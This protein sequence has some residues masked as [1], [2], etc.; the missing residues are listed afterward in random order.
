[1]LDLAMQRFFGMCIC[2]K[3]HAL[4]Q[5]FLLTP[6]KSLIFLPLDS[7][8]LLECLKFIIAPLK[9]FAMFIPR[10]KHHALFHTFLFDRMMLL[11]GIKLGSHF[12]LECF[13]LNIA[14]LNL[15]A[16]FI[17]CLKHHEMFR[18]LLFSLIT[19]LIRFSL[20][21]HSHHNMGQH[22]Y[23]VDG[24]RWHSCC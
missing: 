19:L 20:G 21:S 16:K 3:L 17:P 9:F 8:F 4:F 24:Y 2:L 7:H 13:K 15:F 10:L 23:G 22:N 18:T 6:M 12:L 5:T 1:M 14:G 11:K